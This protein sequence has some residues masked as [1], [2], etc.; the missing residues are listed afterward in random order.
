MWL[1]NVLYESEEVSNKS[2]QAK[3]KRK[4]IRALS[5]SDVPLTIPELQK[6]VRISTPTTIKLINE[7]ITDLLVLEEGKKETENGRRPTLYTLNIDKFH[8]IGVEILFKRISIAV[9]RLDQKVILEKQD[10]NFRL[11]NTPEC[12]ETV[13]SFIQETLE[14]CQIGKEHILGIG[15]GLT[16]RVNTLTG[17][18]YNFFNFREEPLAQHLTKRLQKQIFIDNDTHVMGLAEQVLGQAKEAKNALVLNVSRG[19]GMTIIAHKKII[20]GGMGFAGEF[21]HMQMSNSEKLCICGKRGCLGME[22]S[23]YALE[24]NFKS[25]IKKGDI[26]LASSNKILDD[27]RYDDII[28]ATNEGDALSINLLQEMGEKLGMALGNI[29]NLL[30]PELIIVGGKF[31]QAGYM[32]TDSIKTGMNKTALTIPLRYLTIKTSQLGSETGYIGASAMVFKQ[33]DLI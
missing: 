6:Q 3:Q 28:N 21:G 19:L 9:V 32:F 25:D 15:I 18:S 10:I 20:T 12:L 27:I 23:G 11:E 1:N 13:I 22:V 2:R 5:K 26:S 30:N 29:V 31:A 14:E 7:L 17:E 33:H 16:G 24:E 8:A 4:I